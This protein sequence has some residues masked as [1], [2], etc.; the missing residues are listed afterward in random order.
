V[1]LI[2]RAFGEKKGRIWLILVVQ[3]PIL[4]GALKQDQMQ[5]GHYWQRTLVP[6]SK[7]K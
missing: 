6:Q 7:L 4:G 5:S 2:T 1:N 3:I